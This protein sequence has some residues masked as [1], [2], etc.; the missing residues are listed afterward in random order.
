MYDSE[1]QSQL[2]ISTTLSA[3]RKLLLAYKPGDALSRTGFSQ[4]ASLS[5]SKFMFCETN[6]TFAA[7]SL[8][9]LFP[10]AVWT[11]E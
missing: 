6:T 8:D 2:S 7:L 10:L 11:F 3:L 5:L 4:Q 9:N 1:L